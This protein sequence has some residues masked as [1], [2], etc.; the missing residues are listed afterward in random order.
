MPIKI[1]ITKYAVLTSAGLFVPYNN[2]DFG[3]GLQ[4]TPIFNN[5]KDA[6]TYIL[7]IEKHYPVYFGR[8]GVFEVVFKEI[9]RS[10]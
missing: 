5:R 2:V 6:E 10:F 8:C 7:H 3:D 4:N 9:I 1:T